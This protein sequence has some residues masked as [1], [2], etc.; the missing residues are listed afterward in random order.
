MRTAAPR[1]VLIGVPVVLL[2]LPAAAGAWGDRTH[3]AVNRLAVETLPTAAAA[4]Y[5]PHLE[6]LARRSVEPDSVMRAREGEAEKIRH[7]IDLDAYMPAP[8]TGFPRRYDEAVRRYGRRR[9]ERRGVLPWVIVRFTNQ[10]QDAIRDRDVPRAVREAAYLGHYVADAYQPLHLTE[11][12]DGQLSGA[13][14]VHKRFEDGL[15]DEHVERYESDVRRRLRPAAVP[16]DIREAVFSAMIRS[17]VEVGPLL[18]ADAAARAVARPPAPA[19]Y[20]MLDE[21]TAPM[22]EHQLAAAVSMLGSLW[23]AAWQEAGRP[24]PAPPRERAHCSARHRLPSLARHANRVGGSCLTNHNRVAVAFGHE[25]HDVGVVDVEQPDAQRASG[26]LRRS[27]SIN[28]V[29]RWRSHPFSASGGGCQAAAASRSAWWWLVP[30]LLLVR[31]RRV[32][33][34]GRVH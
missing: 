20:A 29:S 4:F 17:Y 12:Y 8:F 28:R 19:Y 18:E 10:L 25:L 3:A 21:R 11:N 32:D 16:A 26:H 6:E 2:V 13:R 5:R 7:F 24:L 30:I 27:G 9:V 23:L 33:K 34:R 22:V 31:C 14:G 15:V 1:R